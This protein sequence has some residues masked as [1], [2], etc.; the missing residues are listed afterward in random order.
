M[1][2]AAPADDTRPG[3]PGSRFPGRVPDAAEGRL[4]QSL[5]LRRPGLFRAPPLTVPPLAVP[6][7]VVQPLAVPSPC[8][9][10]RPA[11][12]RRR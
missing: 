6:P 11:G 7:L 2:G 9:G 5:H 8:L 4:R 3:Q 1:T 10:P 12:L